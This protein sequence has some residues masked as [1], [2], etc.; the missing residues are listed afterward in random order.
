MSPAPPTDEPQGSCIVPTLDVPLDADRVWCAS[1]DLAW[2]TLGEFLGGSVAI[3]G[4]PDGPAA[5]HG[6]ALAASTVAPGD[7][8]PAALVALAGLQT[9]DWVAHAEAQIRRRL[10]AH[11]DLKRLPREPQPNLL[12]AYAV[13]AKSWKFVLPFERLNG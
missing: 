3:G 12:V 8:D 4:P 7:L 10:G 13:L 9:P 5:A 2:G 1:F 11:A 6:R